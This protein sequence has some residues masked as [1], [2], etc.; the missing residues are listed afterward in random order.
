MAESKVERNKRLKKEKLEE[1]G[2]ELFMNNTF[3]K[4]SIDQIVKKAGVAKGTFYLYFEDKT[5]LL[6]RI[7]MKK[8]GDILMDALSHANYLQL[9]NKLDQFIV[10]VDCIL[11]YFKQNQNIL[12]VVRNHLSWDDI[13]TDMKNHQNFSIQIMMKEYIELIM[14]NKNY[15]EKEAIATL[16]VI[17]E[18]VSSVAYASIIVKKPFELL[19]IKPMLYASIRSMIK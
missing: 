5:Q 18:L 6:N 15:T 1:S 17:F 14:T 8:S 2:Y 19:E 7:I 10:M 3:D 4:T 11:D 16:Y 9:D 12:E 13:L